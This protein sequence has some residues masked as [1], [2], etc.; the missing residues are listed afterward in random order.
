MEH[1]TRSSRALGIQTFCRTTFRLRKENW[2]SPPSTT[3]FTFPEYAV[4][5]NAQTWRKRKSRRTRVSSSN[6]WGVE[7]PLGGVKEAW[8]G[9]PMEA[10]KGSFSKQGCT[11]SVGTS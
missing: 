1:G 10:A 9:D 3:S 2:A 8:R 7:R 6:E 4:P 5:H 11:C